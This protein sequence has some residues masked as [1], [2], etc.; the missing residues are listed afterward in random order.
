MMNKSK[1]LLSNTGISE[2]DKRLTLSSV[3]LCDLCML[4]VDAQRLALKEEQE[5]WSLVLQTRTPS[6]LGESQ[7]LKR[8]M[9][10]VREFILYTF[11]FLLVMCTQRKRE[12]KRKSDI[13]GDVHQCHSHYIH[14]Q[15]TCFR[16]AEHFRML[17]FEEVWFCQ[18]FI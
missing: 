13:Q 3:Q 11:F 2:E 16:F 12:K 18:A 10:F 7:I 6:A 4:G 14:H 8:Q 1:T 9:R 15:V 5:D 17:L